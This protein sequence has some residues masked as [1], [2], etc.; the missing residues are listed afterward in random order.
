MLAHDSAT[1]SVFLAGGHTTAAACAAPEAANGSAALEDIAPERRMMHRDVYLHDAFELDRRT[2]TW[3]QLRRA[4][5]L[6]VLRSGR[7]GGA[8]VA[9]GGT[10]YVLGGRLVMA[11]AA[12]CPGDCNVVHWHACA[13]CGAVAS[14]YGGALLRCGGCAA[15]GCTP[16][17]YCGRACQAAD[18][19]VHRQ[20]C[21]GGDVARR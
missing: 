20:S 9:T 7:A 8:A 16:V 19:G 15:A 12:A 11:G 21:N 14:K 5:G 10:L 13:V 2:L 1:G 4:D 18:W 3:R 17:L 6:P